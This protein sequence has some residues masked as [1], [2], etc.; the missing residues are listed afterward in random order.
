MA[1]IGLL[2]SPKVTFTEADFAYGYCN[3]NIRNAYIFSENQPFP[4][5]A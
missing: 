5:I 4:T 2:G 3:H 1:I